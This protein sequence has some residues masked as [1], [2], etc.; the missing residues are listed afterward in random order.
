M[1]GCMQML[2]HEQLPVPQ[3]MR[4]LSHEQP[5]SRSALLRALMAKLAHHRCVQ[6]SYGK[7]SGNASSPRSS[8]MC[9]PFEP[10]HS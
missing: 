4:L 8:P 1:P 5:Q 10:Q 9:C 3:L 2:V 6:A 7:K